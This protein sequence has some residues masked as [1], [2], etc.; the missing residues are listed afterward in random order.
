MKRL[1]LTIAA[2]IIMFSYGRRIL[3]LFLYCVRFYTRC[4]VF[5]LISPTVGED[6]NF[7]II[8]IIFLI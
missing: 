8:N 4:N 5:A 6:N 1:G 3:F 2:D 7:V